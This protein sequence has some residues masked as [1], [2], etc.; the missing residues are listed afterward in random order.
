[1]LFNVC[2]YTPGSKTSHLNFLLLQTQFLI[3]SVKKNLV[4]DLSQSYIKGNAQ[5]IFLYNPPKSS[6]N[7]CLMKILKRTV[8]K[9]GNCVFL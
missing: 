7:V 5:F 6:V 8:T 2:F 3:T 1:M 4:D 9:R